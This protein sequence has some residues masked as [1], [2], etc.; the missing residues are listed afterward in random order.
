VSELSANAVL[1]TASGS[2][3]G[4]FHLAVAVSPRVVALSVTDEGGADMVPKARR[5]GERAEHGR[6]LSMVSTL[7][8]RVVVHD[9]HGGY[10]VTAELLTGAGSPE[11]HPC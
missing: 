6:G 10:T 5:Q 9:H 1:Y 3:S 11:E 4:S 7:A 8:H 2:R